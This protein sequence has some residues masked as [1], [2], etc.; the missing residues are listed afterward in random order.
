MAAFG[1]GGESEDEAELAEELVGVQADKIP[2]TAS[3]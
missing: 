1:L 3:G 2:K